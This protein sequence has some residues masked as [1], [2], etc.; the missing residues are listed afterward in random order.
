MKRKEGELVAKIEIL[1]ESLE[2]ASKGADD[3]KNSVKTS[4][5]LTKK[6]K[7]YVGGAKWSGETRDAF[8]AYL[9]IIVQYHE[10]LYAATKLQTTAFNH[11]KENIAAFDSQPEAAK[12]RSL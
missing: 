4:L 5:D 6:L 2:Q 10:D 9:D 8:E 1:G 7:S 3:L 11:L 12:V